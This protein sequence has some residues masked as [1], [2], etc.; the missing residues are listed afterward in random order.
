MEL[1]RQKDVMMAQQQQLLQ[2]HHHQN[3]LFDVPSNGDDYLIHEHVGPD[4]R[5]LYS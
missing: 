3:I 1:R 2:L 5:H 4:F